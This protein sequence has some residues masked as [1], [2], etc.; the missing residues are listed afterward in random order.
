MSS[1]SPKA[2]DAR[3]PWQEPTVKPV[4]TVAEVLKGGSGKVTV[5]TGDPGEPQKVS[6][7]E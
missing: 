5:I 7:T 6:P 3:Q 2:T 4:G 1:K